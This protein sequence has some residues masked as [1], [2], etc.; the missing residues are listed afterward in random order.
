MN[1][2]T[3]RENDFAIGSEVR[4]KGLAA[5]ILTVHGVTEGEVPPGDSAR[6]ALYLVR[7]EEGGEASWA[8]IAARHLEAK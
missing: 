3:C 2:W 7:W 4:F 5:P 6:E 1:A 8:S